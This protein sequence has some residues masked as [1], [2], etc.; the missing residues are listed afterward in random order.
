MAYVTTDSSHWRWFFALLIIILVEV[1]N[2][3]RGWAQASV[4]T[5]HNDNF[6]T[7]ANTSE[8]QLT[9]ANVGGG[10][11][12]KLFDQLVDGEIYAQPLYVP[13][14]NI[15]GKGTHNLLIVN[16]EGDSVYAFDA[17]SNSGVNATPLW[18]ASLIDTAHGATSGATT[19]P[20]SVYP[21]AGNGAPACNN[22]NP[23]YG[24]TATPVID[25][26]NQV[27]YVEAFSYEGGTYV[28]RLHALD[29][30][31]GA[32]EPY[33]PV[34][35]TGAVAGT[36]DGGSTITFNAFNHN[37]RPALLLSN[38][39]VYVAYGASCGDQSTPFHGWVFAYGAGTLSQLGSFV[40]TPYGGMGGIWMSGAGLAAD[41]AGN[42]YLS[43]GNGDFDT[44]NNPATDFG[45]SVL[46]LTLTGSAL[47]ISDYF[48]PFNQATLSSTDKD[49]ASGGLVL[50]PDQAGAYPHELVTAGKEG[51]IYV[52]NRDQFTLSNQHYCA[53]CSSDPQIVQESA[54]GI[55]NGSFSS[56]VYWN[57][58]VYFWTSN[59]Y[60]KA[61]PISNGTV[62]FSSPSITTDAFKFPGA[63]VAVSADGTSNG[64]VWA[65][66]TNGY[67]T[68]NP[69]VLRAYDASNLA[70][71][72]YSSDQVAGDA[73]GA[74]V[75]FAVPT[76]V[77]GKVYLGS[78]D[79][80]SVYGLSSS[81]PTPTPTPTATVSGT[82]TPASTPTATSTATDTP[83]AT[84]T[85]TA[86]ATSTPTDTPTATTTATVTNTVT[87]TVTSTATSTGT[88]TPTDTPTATV[89]V[90]QTRTATATTTPTATDTPTVSS[91]VTPTGT[92]TATATLSATV[93]PTRTPTATATQTR[94]PTA[95]AS[96]TRTATPSATLTVTPTGTPTVT[97]T[98]TRT[99]TTT[100]TPTSTS[101]A[102]A[103]ATSTATFTS[104]AT[105][106]VT[107]TV[108]PTSTPTV[109][110]TATPTPVSIT[111]VTA[112]PVR[113]GFGGV[114][115]T[116][117]SKVHRLI[118]RNQGNATALFNEPQTATAPALQPVA[119]TIA[120]NGCSAPLLPHQ[121]CKIDLL[122]SP[123]I[124][125]RLTGALM[126]PYNG[127]SVQ[128]ALVG[129]GLPA[130]A[131]APKSVD[132][133]NAKVGQ[134]GRTL[135]IKI[136]NNDPITL[137]LGARNPLTSNFTIVA[138]GCS[139]Q[140]LAPRS[141]CIVSLTFAPQTGVSG[142]VN[143]SLGYSYSYGV[144][145]GVV[146]SKLVGHAR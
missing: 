126:V 97:V 27:I 40:T 35:V 65:V 86:T 71:R 39:V 57:N 96:A 52:L 107:T 135:K 92:S 98:A 125:G 22:I 140:T 61:F 63:Q 12:G 84:A 25:A 130:K 9:P 116:G 106:S 19:V 143:D 70:T 142:P 11:F 118:L 48:T 85:D 90:T 43:S 75:R 113:V 99:A 67:K 137:Q 50:L 37:A 51:R 5:Y 144:N 80:V 111:A 76:V 49:L 3:G 17:D 15:P 104:T 136:A 8:T 55:I 112:A 41:T 105:P 101:T 53:N 42:V 36:G 31:T 109:T 29:L 89:T 68:G 131:N 56:P 81:G 132:F 14:I 44:V 82:P 117:S 110:P 7:G 122:F 69:A 119:F 6:R 120:N 134:A 24:S 121:T 30:T 60:L 34:V 18:Q 138:D 2:S 38:G 58:T 87:P 115:A 64:I 77:N 123:P 32:E 94:T 78:H 10:N 26:T 33:S 103:T 21:T 128:V 91:T 133:G 129:T 88:P 23:Q 114:H 73:P 79:R 141:S 66:S 83:T 59:L 62:D 45:D 16:T 139:N 74:A 124:P 108:T 20:S 13:N 72:L 102:S 146:T 54:S 127:G 1:L 93:T 100:A 4:L 95:T 47:G 46:K 28:H 145:T